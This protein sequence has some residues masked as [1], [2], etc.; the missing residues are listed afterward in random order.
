MIQES[1]EKRE[2]SI[3]FHQ[4]EH[5]ISC[6]NLNAALSE[7][8]S[9][10]QIRY[11]LD[12]FDLERLNV[13]YLDGATTFQIVQITTWVQFSDEVRVSMISLGDKIQNRPV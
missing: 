8:W 9:G 11:R 12:G 1:P 7:L 6:I 2:D 10:R 4:V 3:S 13:G 5:S